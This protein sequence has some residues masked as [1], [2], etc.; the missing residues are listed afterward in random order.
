MFKK[1]FGKDLAEPS[2]KNMVSQ[3]IS[4]EQLF[5]L[6]LEYSDEFWIVC[7]FISTKFILLIDTNGIIWKS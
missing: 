2:K 5:H 3:I 4:R 7:N 6:I 1:K